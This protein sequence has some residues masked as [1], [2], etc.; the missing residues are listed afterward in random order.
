MNNGII[1]AGRPINQRGHL[2]HAGY[3]IGPYVSFRALCGRARDCKPINDSPNSADAAFDAKKL[4]ER[5]LQP[6]P[7]C[8]RI[9]ENLRPS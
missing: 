3:G 8:R 4:R 5:G 9:V 7:R 2:F 6:C 1:I